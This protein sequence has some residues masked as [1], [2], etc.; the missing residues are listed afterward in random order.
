MTEA[1]LQTLQGMADCMHMVR[2]EL[3]EAG[4]VEKSVPPMMVAN[5]VLA[6]AGQLI[7]DYNQAVDS[8]AMLTGDVEDLS[9][10]LMA[11]QA[12]AQRFAACRHAARTMPEDGGE[13]AFIASIDDYITKHGI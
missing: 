7:E 10:R 11:L 2:Q 5:A 13:D 4:I 9:T 1:E 3:I 6:Y 8:I 12:E